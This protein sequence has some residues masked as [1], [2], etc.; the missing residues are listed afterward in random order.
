M[1][2]IEFDEVSELERRRYTIEDLAALRF[3]KDMNF[4]NIAIDKE[5]VKI[6]QF[7]AAKL[8][9]KEELRR[10]LLEYR[11]NQHGV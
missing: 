11:Y 1:A 3:Q 5:A 9:D 4:L 6:V 8:K 2:L 7:C 10:S